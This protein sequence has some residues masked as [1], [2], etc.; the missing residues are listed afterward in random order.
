MNGISITGKLLALADI[1]AKTPAIKALKNDA[2]K[3]LDAAVESQMDA[4]KIRYVASTASTGNFY[5]NGTATQTA[6]KSLDKY[7]LKT[8]VDY[9]MGTMYCPPADGEFYFGILTVTAARDLH[10][11]LEAIWQLNCE[12]PYEP[13]YKMAA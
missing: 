11:S 13:P 12:L 3:T 1:D 4:C 2:A 6:S 5:T 8:I 7:H 10:D 9:M